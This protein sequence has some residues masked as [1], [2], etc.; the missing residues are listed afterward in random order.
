MFF[1]PDAMRFALPFALIGM[2]LY[3]KEAFYKLVSPYMAS[4][5]SFYLIVLSCIP[6]KEQR[7]MLPC[8][9]YLYL[10][11]GLAF[12]YFKT[13]IPRILA[14]FFILNGFYEG[15][16]FVYFNTMTGLEYQPLRYLSNN[17]PDIYSMYSFS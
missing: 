16:R 2:F 7:F 9:P 8:L 5:V 11:T 6:H 10:M 12:E 4:F 15:A 1:L 14:V 17:E 3:M 13:R